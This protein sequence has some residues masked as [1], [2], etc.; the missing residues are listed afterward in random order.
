MALPA[1]DLT[2]KEKFL[3][4]IATGN[5]S[6]LPDPLTR[7]E[8]YL[9]YIAL[10]GGGGGGGTSDYNMLS[11]LPKINGHTVKGNMDSDDLGLDQPLTTEQL[12]TL[13]AMI[14]D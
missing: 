8:E 9:Q 6:D 2:R 1:E 11:N 13:L 3:R 14:P 12:N 5:V 10:N 4:G 7:E